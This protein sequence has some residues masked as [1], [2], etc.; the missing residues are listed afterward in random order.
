MGGLPDPSPIETTPVG[1]KPTER[2]VRIVSL[3]DDFVVVDKDQREPVPPGRDGAPARVWS[4]A[5]G[6]ALTPGVFALPD[7]VPQPRF[8]ARGLHLELL[9]NPSRL[10]HFYFHLYPLLVFTH[11]PLQSYFDFNAVFILL[12]YVF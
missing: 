10:V 5:A 1:R 6:A 11:I 12:Q 4:R 9:R 3:Q 2:S 7:R 8:R